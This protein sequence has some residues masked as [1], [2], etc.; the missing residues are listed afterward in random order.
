M[1]LPEPDWTLETGFSAPC[2]H[3]KIFSCLLHSACDGETFCLS[4]VMGC[5]P[6]IFPETHVQCCKCLLQPAWHKRKF[7]CLKRE[8]SSSYALL[9]RRWEGNYSWFRVVCTGLRSFPESH[10]IQTCSD[11]IQV[12]ND[13]LPPNWIYSLL[14]PILCWKLLLL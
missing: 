13:Q 6:C 8:R 12:L 4:V 9:T 1:L 10:I 5:A 14:F 11:L 7:P 2:P 3:G